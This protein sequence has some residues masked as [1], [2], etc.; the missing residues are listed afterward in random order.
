MP[1]QLL[2]EADGGQGLEY[3]VGGSGKQANLLA[4]DDGNGAWL[5]ELL[6]RCFV[7]ILLAQG[8]DQGRAARIGILDAS[9]GFADVIEIKGRVRVKVLYSIEI[10]EKV[11]EELAGA[12]DKRLADTRRLH[13]QVRSYADDLARIKVTKVCRSE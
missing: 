7:G 6:E 13:I 10:V 3:R 4:G 2:S 11:A 5:G 8:S 12:G 9:G 1:V